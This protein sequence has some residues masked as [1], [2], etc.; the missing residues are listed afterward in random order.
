MDDIEMRIIGILFLTT[1][2]SILVLTGGWLSN[3]VSIISAIL[4][5]LGVIII[6]KN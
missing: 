2:C 3:P 1:G 5:I 4:Q 6:L